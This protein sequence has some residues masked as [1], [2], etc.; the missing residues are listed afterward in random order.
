MP[1]RLA[2]F[3][4]ATWDYTLYSEGFLASFPSNGGLDD[5][6]SAFIS[7][8]EFI[9]HPVLDPHYLSIIDFVKATLEKKSLPVGKLS[10]LQL[11]DSLEQDYNIVLSLIRQLRPAAKSATLLCELDDLETWAYLSNYF[12][13]KLKAGVALHTYR[14]SADENQKQKAIAYLKTCA[15]AWKRICEITVHHY[16]EVPYV[17]NP[18]SNGKADFDARTFSWSK[19]L[20]QVE[21]DI[22]LAEQSKTLR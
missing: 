13:F 10:P 9:D 1:L 8:D 6:V 16:Y 19:Y 5:K 3:H 15:S 20:P 4:A 12:A 7:I 21:R 11:A 18:S 2:S 22:M 14:L 17:D